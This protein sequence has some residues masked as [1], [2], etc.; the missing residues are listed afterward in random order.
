MLIRYNGW[1]CAG[2]CEARLVDIANVRALIFFIPLT[3]KLHIAVRQ[4]LQLA[5]LGA[6]AQPTKRPTIAKRE[7]QNDQM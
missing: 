5:K 3:T 4:A 7:N 1:L 2:R 6:L